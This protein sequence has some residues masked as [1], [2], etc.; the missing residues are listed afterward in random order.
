MDSGMGKLRRRQSQA[1]EMTSN[2]RQLHLQNTIIAPGTDDAAVC[3]QASNRTTN[4]CRTGSCHL[5][6]AHTHTHT[7]I[8]GLCASGG[9][10]RQPPPSA[11]EHGSRWPVWT[12]THALAHTRAHARAHAHDGAD[13]RHAAHTNK[14]MGRAN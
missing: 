8:V 6:G 1:V 13:E 5:A 9:A 14:H 11:G 10:H 12:S 3:V 2:V 7:R 4:N